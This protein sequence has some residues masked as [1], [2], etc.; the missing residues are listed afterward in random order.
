MY[1]YDVLR[2]VCANNSSTKK[3][4]ACQWLD[5][6]VLQQW[7]LNDSTDKLHGLYIINIQ[8]FYIK[9]YSD[10]LIYDNIFDNVDNNSTIIALNRSKS[11]K[12]TNILQSTQ[13]YAFWKYWT[14][15]IYPLIDT[16]LRI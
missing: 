6:C 4:N 7:C 16:W 11:G 9:L 2:M 1:T 5:N 12:H 14:F 13:V 8:A 15:S 3:V 10:I